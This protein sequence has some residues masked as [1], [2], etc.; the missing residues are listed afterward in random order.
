MNRSSSTLGGQ[1]QELQDLVSGLRRSVAS[2]LP[3]EGAGE[4]GPSSQRTLKTCTACRTAKVVC[5][6]S[7]GVAC[8]RC[9]THDSPCEWPVQRK[10]G[11]KVTNPFVP[12]SSQCPYTHG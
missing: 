12:L 4:P 11:R 10:M 2:C 7:P 5:K 3:D 1:Q 6:G 9:Q 8:P